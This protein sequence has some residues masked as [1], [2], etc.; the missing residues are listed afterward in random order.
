MKKKI[1][2]LLSVL[3]VAF[4]LTAC[5]LGDL[6]TGLN[7]E[8]SNTASDTNTDTNTDTDTDTG[9]DSDT[10]TGSHGGNDQ[11]D[12]YLYNAFTVNEKALLNNYFGFVIPFVANDEYELNDLSA[13][14]AQNYDACVEFYAV[15]NTKAEYN[16]FKALFTE[17]SGYTFEEKYIDDYG[18]TCYVYSKNGAY[19]DM[20]Y[21]EIENDYAIAVYIYIEKEGAGGSGG[22]SGTDFTA[23]E[24]TLFNEYFG[25]V[26]PF[27]ESDEYYVQEYEYSTKRKSA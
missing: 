10:D 27:I 18:D 16:A 8:N 13:E 4:S 19:I 11:Q 22:N 21:Y 7:S 23:D 2:A 26:I 1:I 20:S 14:Y 17:E 5:S 3:T 25:F 12:K 24:K 9:T 6:G 15:G